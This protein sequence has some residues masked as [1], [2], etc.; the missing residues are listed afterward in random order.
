MRIRE[1]FHL[2]MVLAAAVA[3]GFAD[4]KVAQSRFEKI[5]DEGR[6]PTDDEWA[7]LNKTRDELRRRMLAA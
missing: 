5:L 1:A 7:E 6:D 3:A 2:G 4:A